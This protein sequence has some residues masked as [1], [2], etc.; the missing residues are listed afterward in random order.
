VVYKNN[1]TSEE[2]LDVMLKLYYVYIY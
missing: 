2:T 1:I